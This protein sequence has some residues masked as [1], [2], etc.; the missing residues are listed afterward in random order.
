MAE[1]SPAN[2][3][4]T[5]ASSRNT[6]I[7]APATTEVRVVTAAPPSASNQPPVKSALVESPLDVGASAEVIA[8]TASA[9]NHRQRHRRPRR[10]HH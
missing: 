8:A 7:S 2:S 5:R 6:S 10:L 4:R 1:N 3:A 9:M